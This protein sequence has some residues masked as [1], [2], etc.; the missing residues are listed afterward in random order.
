M[1]SVNI[2]I[3]DT[4]SNLVVRKE[5]CEKRKSSD[6]DEPIVAYLYTI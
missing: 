1:Y 3:D 4:L 2:T 5:R 6:N